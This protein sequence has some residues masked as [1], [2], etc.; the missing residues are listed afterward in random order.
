M[1][2]MPFVGNLTVQMYVLNEQNKTNNHLWKHWL[3]FIW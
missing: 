1:K 3:E 2:F